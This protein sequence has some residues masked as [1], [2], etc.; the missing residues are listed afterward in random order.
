M[1]S[2]TTS[3]SRNVVGVHRAGR[4]ESGLGADY[5]LVALKFTRCEQARERRADRP[6]RALLTIVDRRIEEIDS[7]A[8]RRGDG[9]V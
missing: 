5:N 6:L 3:P 4:E 7:T 8:D 9:L 2:A 1:H